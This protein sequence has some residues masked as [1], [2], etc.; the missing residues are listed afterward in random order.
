[1]VG[2]GTGST[3]PGMQSEAGR[4]GYRVLGRSVR[5]AA[6]CDRAVEAASWRAGVGLLLFGI[7][8]VL[9]IAVPVALPIG[10]LLMRRRGRW[11]RH[12]PCGRCRRSTDEVRGEDSLT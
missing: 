6:R 12:S 9:S 5:G 7:G 1:M 8:L 10:L 11:L 4:A 2:P 3:A